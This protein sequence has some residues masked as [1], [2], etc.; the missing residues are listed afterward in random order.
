MSDKK[1][2]ILM[3]TY[4]RSQVL[5]LYRSILRLHARELPAEMRSLGDS[6]V[7]SE[8]QLHKSVTD[9]SGL[10]GFF[11]G[12]EDYRRQMAEGARKAAAGE[13]TLGKNLPG[14][15]KLSDEQMEKLEEL[16]EEASKIGR[17]DSMGRTDN[18]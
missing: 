9:A 16:R 8:F 7:R 14:D 3:S 2:E 12:W 5:S 6:Y 11:R 13:G 10:A 1:Q 15:A 4:S 17:G 18:G